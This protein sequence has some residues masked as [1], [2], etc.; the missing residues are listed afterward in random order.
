[1]TVGEEQLR[2]ALSEL[3]PASLVRE[4]L[5]ASLARVVT[6][7]TSAFGA[8]GA[9]IMLV[10][11]DQGLRFVSATDP[12]SAALEAVEQRTG[13]GPCADALVLDEVVRCSDLS[14]ERRWPAVREALVPLGARAILGVPLHVAGTPIGALDVYRLRIH[15]WDESEIAAIR[16]YADVVEELLGLAVLAGQRHGLA[17]QLHHA[18]EHRVVVERAVGYLMAKQA[19]DPVEAFNLLRSQ[20]RHERRR[21]AELAEEILGRTRSVRPTVSPGA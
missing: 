21:V 8:D 10:D 19:L 5:D 14:S 13:E 7:V 11:E 15:E 3:D 12:V 18:L 6:S 16:S 4:A 1:V 2:A 17:E 9:G 20:A